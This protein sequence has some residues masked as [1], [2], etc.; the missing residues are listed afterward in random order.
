LLDV[1]GVVA[2]EPQ[3][4][5]KTWVEPM[6]PVGLATGMGLQRRYVEHHVRGDPARTSDNALNVPA[7]PLPEAWRQSSDGPAGRS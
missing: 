6:T 4:H 5:L 2:V 3:T 7:P 1:A